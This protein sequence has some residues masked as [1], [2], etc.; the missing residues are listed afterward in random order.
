MGQAAIKPSKGAVLGEVDVGLEAIYLLESREEHSTVILKMVPDT[1]TPRKTRDYRTRKIQSMRDVE[2]IDMELHLQDETECSCSSLNSC[3]IGEEGRDMDEQQLA[4]VYYSAYYLHVPHEV[5]PAYGTDGAGSTDTTTEQ[6]FKELGDIFQMNDASMACIEEEVSTRKPPNM[7]LL[8]TVHEARDLRPKTSKATS[9][10]YCVVRVSGISETFKTRVVNST[11]APSWES[12]FNTHEPQEAGVEQLIGMRDFRELS[13]LVRDAAASI[14]MKEMRNLLG[15]VTVPLLELKE[16]SIE[17]WYNLTKSKEEDTSQA[18]LGENCKQ[19]K[20]RGSIRLSLK[21]S[22]VAEL[23]LIGPHWFDAFLKK[24]VRHYLGC[25][26]TYGNVRRGSKRWSERSMHSIRRSTKSAKINTN[27][28]KSNRL[29]IN[30]KD[31]STS[32][33]TSSSSG[34][35]VES[36]VEWTLP[37]PWNGNLSSTAQSLLDHYAATLNLAPPTTLLSWWKVSSE[38]FI[39]DQFFLGKLLKDIQGYMKEKRYSEEEIQEISSS[40]RTWT[41]TQIDRL[42]NLTTYFPSSTKIVSDPQLRGMLRNFYAVEAEPQMRQLRVFPKDMFVTELVKEALTDFTKNWWEACLKNRGRNSTQS[43]EDQQLVAAVSVAGEVFSFLSEVSCFYHDVFLRQAEISYLRLTYILLTSE[44]AARVRPLL[45]KIYAAPPTSSLQHVEADRQSLEAGTPVWQLYKKLESILKIGENLPSEVH[46]QSDIQGFHQWFIGGVE[47]WQRK[48]FARARDL[49]SKE[50]ERDTFK[51]DYP[52]IS[53]YASTTSSDFTISSSASGCKSN[54]TIIK[55]SWHKLAWPCE[56]GDRAA[57][58]LLQDLCGLGAHYTKLVIAKLDS[59]LCEENMINSVFLPA[60]ICIGLN[61][62]EYM[63]QE[64]E[65]LKELFDL[66]EGDDREQICIISNTISQMEGAVLLFMDNVLK[67]IKPVLFKA[68]VHSCETGNEA[69]LLQEVLDEG[70]CALLQRLDNTNFQRFLQKIWNLLIVI[71]CNNVESNSTKRNAEYFKGVY[72]VLE[73]TWYFFT[74]TDRRGLDPQQAST[75]EYQSLQKKLCNLKMATE[76]LIAKYYRERFEEL[77]RAHQSCTAELIVQAFFM[78]T[79][80]LIV[81]VVMARNIIVPAGSLPNTFVQLKL[82]PSDWFPNV[83][84]SKTKPKKS[85]S[86]VFSEKFEFAISP[87]DHGVK[88][89]HLLFVLKTRQLFQTKVIGEAV[90]P[91]DELETTT[92]NS[93]KNKILNM[94]IPRNEDDYTS[95][96]ALKYRTWDKKAVSFLQKMST[97]V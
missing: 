82:V 24:V 62:I 12:K 10:P 6:L 88:A 64:V 70:L 4:D 33:S 26:S 15:T 96:K 63:R 30:D 37:T 66:L 68:V 54:F 83:V 5:P 79:G 27:N 65:G 42:R 78:R 85:G 56:V 17:G 41:S 21:V 89:G 7:T 94:N 39:I 29:N 60:E 74:P 91:L 2:E 36:E 35:S 23:N 44:L 31:Y 92:S 69:Q 55:N 72:K 86:P 90:V 73:R 16:Q 28:N 45:I 38:F 34:S 18:S 50:V 20:K 84:V 9:H 19:S 25:L 57:K 81:E 52:G 1:H 11:L 46:L 8:I 58:R 93:A 14:Q 67:K 95:V 22:T 53:S 48:L 75:S 13:R 76:S 71:F 77:K 47:R 61:N 51:I 3:H 59:K 97:T 32:C 87:A 43:T 40:L 49:I 80:R